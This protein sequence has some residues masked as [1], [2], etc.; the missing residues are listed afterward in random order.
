M[1]HSKI[2]II[3]AGAVGTTTAFALMQ[4]NTVAEIILVD[5]DT[6]RCHGEIL[7][8]ADAL[9]FCE[10]S[11]VRAGTTADAQNA[12]IIIIAAGARQEPNQKRTELIAHNKKTIELIAQHIYPVQKNAIII[13]VTNPVDA[14][15][16][17]AQK[18]FD[19]PR[20][21]IFG[22]G[23]FLDTQRLRGLLAEK[24]NVAQQAIHA[25]ILGEHGDTQFPVWSSAHIDGSPIDAFAQLNEKTKN[26]LAQQTRN[27]AYEIIQCK[28]AT[29]FGIAACV[30]QLCEMI[31]FNQKDIA[32]VSTFIE[33]AGICLSM[34]AVIG[35]QGIEKI[36]DVPLNEHEQ[37]QFEKSVKALQNI[38][39]SWFT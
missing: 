30:A 19:L 32:P 22:S 33:D 3:G 23:T 9:P 8:L 14:L 36:I 25:Y 39:Q 5:I 6:Q 38:K 10:S 24:L 21:Q 1:K 16:W 26:E 28:G 37:K 2:A 34:P 4:R 18:L 29:F 35:A 11:Q 17:Y 7:D 13:I 15:T 27:R 12:D 20:N 31:V